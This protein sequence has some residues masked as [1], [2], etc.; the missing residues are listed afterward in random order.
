MTNLTDLHRAN[1]LKLAQYLLSLPVDYPRFCMEEYA[2]DHGGGSMTYLSSK[3]QNWCGTA[4]CALGHG[5]A[6]GIYGSDSCGSW[7]FYAFEQFG[8]SDCTY[9]WSWCFASSWSYVDNTHHGAAKRILYFLD[10]GAPVMNE[11]M[12][13]VKYVDLYTKFAGEKAC[14]S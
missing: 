7:V 14:L 4:A 13:Q 2:T 1:L 3:R 6:A 8:L 5:P 12:F 10:N 9:E 11:S